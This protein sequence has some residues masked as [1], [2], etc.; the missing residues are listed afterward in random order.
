MS[1]AAITTIISTKTGEVLA[2][3]I[4]PVWAGV[5]NSCSIVP[6]SFSLTARAEATRE[7]LMNMMML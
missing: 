4:S 1:D 6:V 3:N 2:S 7:A 5:I